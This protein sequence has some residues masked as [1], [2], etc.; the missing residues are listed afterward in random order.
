MDLN[1]F[2]DQKFD[3]K[4]WINKT[5]RSIDPTGNKE[6]TVSSVMAKLQLFYQEV[7]T[8]LENTSQNV[9]NNLPRVLHEIED[10]SK[11][12]ENLKQKMSAVKQ[13]I[14]NVEK[15]T[16][17][18]IASLEKIDKIKIQLVNAKQALY[19]ADNWTV[20]STDIEAVFETGEIEVIAS[21]LVSMQQSLNALSN[22]SDYEHKKV[23][24]EGLKNRL[25]A[26]ASPYVVE[27]FTTKS[28]EESKKFVKI[29]EDMGRFQLLL[30]YYIKCQKTSLLRE[31]Q[32]MVDLDN[33]ENVVETFQN[34]YDFLLVNWQEQLKWCENVM[35]GVSAVELLVEL[36]ADLL[37][38]LSV[39]F[40]KIFEENMKQAEEPLAWL[41]QVKTCSKG[42][43]SNIKGKISGVN[44]NLTH[45][46]KAI[47]LPYVNHISKFSNA[48]KLMF[49]IHLENLVKKEDTMDMIQTLGQKNSRIF[50]IITDSRKLCMNLTEGCSLPGFLIALEWFIKNYLDLYK[51]LSSAIQERKGNQTDF[52]TFQMCIT[53]LQN[54]GEFTTSVKQI[55]QECVEALLSA[56]AA[57]KKSDPFLSCLNLLL[58]AER[59]RDFSTLVCSV[60]DSN[61]PSLLKTCRIA[62]ETA[63]R[64]IYQLSFKVIFTPIAVLLESVPT[65]PAWKSKA[66]ASELPDYSYAPQEYITQIGQY[67]MNLP[68]LLEPF[69]SLENASL[70]SALSLVGGDYAQLAHE[71]Y[72]S[73]G[74]VELFLGRIADATC[75]AYADHILTISALS[76]GACKQLATDINYLGNVLEDLGYN[77]SEK[78]KNISMLMKLTPGEYSSQSMGCSPQLVAAVRQMRNIISE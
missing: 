70:N 23:Q 69:L 62:L 14:A 2:S 74:F 72:E 75:R 3:S 31:W 12:A 27:A 43:A 59:Q 47:Y 18:S 46:A 54:L 57:L 45:L 49:R 15:N 56:S 76:V 1:S 67:L 64:E 33:D 7:N 35:S 65:A 24:L 10:I 26:L 22:S 52:N 32:T 38:S 8:D 17:A 13:E 16:G 28:T 36:Y 61:E 58:D 53:V 25:E 29:F 40:S 68:Q 30:K 11:E 73:G 41:L 51:S 5:L 63:C 34:Y 78:L 77:L 48:Q 39:D 71:D 66:V 42:F 50:S 6:T 44:L 4:E 37:T 19:E 55:D 60:T 9:M 21:K 20:L